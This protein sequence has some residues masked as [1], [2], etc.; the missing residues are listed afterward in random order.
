M[1]E[2]T[3]LT[4]S[5]TKAWAEECPQWCDGHPTE[6]QEKTSH[7]AM[8]SLMTPTPEGFVLAR[9]YFRQLVPGIYY[10]YQVEG[11]VGYL[12]IEM[13]ESETLGRF[14]TRSNLLLADYEKHVDM[15]CEG[16]KRGSDE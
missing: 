1:K 12:R 5:E 14:E 10:R 3:E 15:W 6:D 16:V 4:L 9:R 11:P 7:V 2:N 8:S 13:N